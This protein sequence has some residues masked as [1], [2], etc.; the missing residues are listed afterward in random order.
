MGDIQRQQVLQGMKAVSAIY[1]VTYSTPLSLGRL[2]EVTMTLLYNSKTSIQIVVM[3]GSL[4][5]GNLP[6]R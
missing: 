1:P 6:F 3:I 4:L 5:L 2:R